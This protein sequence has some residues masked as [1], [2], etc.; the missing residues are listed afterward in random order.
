MRNVACFHDPLPGA[1]VPPEVGISGRTGGHG[2]QTEEQDGG[3]NITFAPASRFPVG[4]CERHHL[5]EIIE[6]VVDKSFS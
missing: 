5:D 1:Q 4:L 3:K 6:S 2:E